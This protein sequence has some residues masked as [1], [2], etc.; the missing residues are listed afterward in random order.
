MYGVDNIIAALEHRDRTSH[1]YISHMNGSAI[2]KLIAAMQ[3]PF[4]MLESCVLDSIDEPVPV[5]PETFLGGSAPLLQ[6]FTLLG[7]PFPT[8]PKFILSTT[9]I[10]RLELFNI[11]TSGY[12][13]PDVMAT[14]LSALPLLKSL[15]IGFRFLPSPPLHV[16]LPP[17]TCAVLPALTRLTFGGKIEYFE[18]FVARI[19]T[20]QLEQL[21]MTFFMDPTID[22]PRLRDFIG[23]IERLK[24]FN[25]ARLEVSRWAIKIKFG[26]PGRVKLK[27]QCETLD[28]PSSMTQSFSRPPPLLP[29]VEQLE[30]CESPWHPREWID[31]PVMGSSLWL[32]LLHFFVAVQDL[33][34]SEKL[35]PPVS[36][37]LQELTGERTMEVLPALRNLS[38]EG[39]QPFGPVEE[40]IKSFV[41][42]RELSDHPVV[43]QAW[44]RRSSP[45]SV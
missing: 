19:D 20:P 16:S 39:L 21:T 35:L 44:E 15:S 10:V 38:L 22:I 23:L 41:A 4:P 30:I 13:S 43:V 40:A 26:S 31:D 33:Y 25:H 17:L 5:L 24:P 34:V 1:I 11:P 29:H 36:A 3:E 2:E 37:T 9:H 12:I 7:I 8:F 27:I 18:D 42:S 6:S 32:E 45:V 28:R 14:C